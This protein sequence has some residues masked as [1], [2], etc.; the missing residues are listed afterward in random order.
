MQR[1]CGQTIKFKRTK[2][3]IHTNFFWCIALRLLSII[4]REN[5]NGADVKKYPRLYFYLLHCTNDSFSGN[6]VLTT[7]NTELS[8][9]E[10]FTNIFSG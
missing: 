3:K 7:L 10:G 2:A 5:E 4:P 6:N 8:S 1:E 9:A